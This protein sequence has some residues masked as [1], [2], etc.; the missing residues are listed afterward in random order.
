[1][2]GP[3]LSPDVRARV[4]AA[5]AARPV[6]PRAVGSRRRASAGI[7]GAIAWGLAGLVA[8]RPGPAGRPAGLFVASS[9]AWLACGLL[10]TWAA[11]SRGRSM[12]GHP[13]GLRV[14]V[15]LC[16]PVMLLCTAVVVTLAFPPAA[17]EPSPFPTHLVC[18]FGTLLFALGPLVAFGYL[19]RESDPVS[20]G[21][22][23]AALGAAAG[24]WGAFGIVLHCGR[25]AFEHVALGH[26]LPVAVLAAAGA[27]LGRVVLAVRARAG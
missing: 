9:I 23:G 26:V 20:P 1:M 25:T 3:G 2:S 7:A 27:L 10:A 18:F 15:A 22:T 17:P 11:V 24:A 16:T 6:A 19:W 13:R 8:L 12:L 5:A 4:L 21:R 14:A